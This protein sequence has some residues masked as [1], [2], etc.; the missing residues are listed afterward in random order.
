MSEVPCQAFG[1]VYYQPTK[2]RCED[3]CA[4][5]T[6]NPCL[7]GIAGVEPTPSF[8]EKDDV[9]TSGVWL[10]SFANQQRGDK[11]STALPVELSRQRHD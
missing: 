8:L 4:T 9:L 6:P 10:F 11:T 7:V 1:L 2:D 3:S 5:V